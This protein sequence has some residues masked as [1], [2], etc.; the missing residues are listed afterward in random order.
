VF[1]ND[2]TGPEYSG[3]LMVTVFISGQEFG[4][5]PR[6]IAT[7]TADGGHT[8][9]VEGPTDEVFSEPARQVGGN[10]YSDSTGI[11]ELGK[12]AGKDLEDLAAQQFSETQESESV[13]SIVRIE[14]TTV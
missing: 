11:V 8:M 9:T 14:E 4:S 12:K 3:Q 5:A 1:V 7:P 13:Q 6:V 2:T 10:D